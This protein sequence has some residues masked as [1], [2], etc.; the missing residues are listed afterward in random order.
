M[1]KILFGT[2]SGYFSVKFKVILKINNPFSLYWFAR[3]SISLNYFQ[4]I[5][6]WKR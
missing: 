2:G 5:L 6:E 3:Y 1:L 4:N